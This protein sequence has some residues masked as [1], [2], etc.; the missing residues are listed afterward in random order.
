MPDP[1]NCSLLRPAA[2]LA[3]VALMFA[4]CA[5]RPPQAK[6]G[7]SAPAIVSA[8]AI[9][10]VPTVPTLT[11]V[12][13]SVEAEAPT[14][15]PPSIEE[16]APPPPPYQP[17]PQTRIDP[18]GTLIRAADD[19]TVILQVVPGVDFGAPVQAR[20][21]AA[22]EAELDVQKGRNLG[23]G[24]KRQFLVV[25][26]VTEIQSIPAG[27]NMPAGGRGTNVYLDVYSLPSHDK[28][29]SIPLSGSLETLADPIANAA[30]HYAMWRQP[31]P[32]P[33]RKIRPPVPDSSH[34]LI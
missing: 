4:G 15:P 23:S 6:S 22:I 30:V 10:S 8:L 18:P 32:S 21:K 12:P 31:L 33:P 27:V 5:T 1:L 25:V 9:V 19:A 20:F 7:Q 2:G 11:E 13:G 29:C 17:T 28:V 24:R 26:T 34:L 14:V 3:A 16:P